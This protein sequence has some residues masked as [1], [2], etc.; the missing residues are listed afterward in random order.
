MRRSNLVVGLYLALVFASGT[1]VG[2]FG[3]M[4]YRPAPARTAGKGSPE[5]FRKKLLDDMRTRLKLSDEQ[6][7]QVDAIYDGTRR[8][9]VE[10]I[11][12]QMKALTDQQVEKVRAVLSEPQRVEY[13]KW[14]AER[15]KAREKAKGPGC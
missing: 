14:R 2:F 3:H 12:P 6:V 5:E 4:L 11:K 1:A 15:G 9:Y 10:K 13:E 7:R 8:E